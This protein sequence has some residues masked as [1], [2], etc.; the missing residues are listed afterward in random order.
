M[1]GKLSKAQIQALKIVNTR[2]WPAGEPRIHWLR[3]TT[4]AALFREG[5]ISARDP[6]HA[7]SIVDLTDTGRAAMKGAE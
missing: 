5:L 3:R 6:G 7:K 1:S 2:N 4:A